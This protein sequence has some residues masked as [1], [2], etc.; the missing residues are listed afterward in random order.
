MRGKEF[1]TKITGSTSA[2][3][4]KI[5]DILEI[6]AGSLENNQQEYFHLSVAATMNTNEFVFYNRTMT[7]PFSRNIPLTNE[8]FK[9][10]KKL[11]LHDFVSD[12]TAPLIIVPYKNQT[13]DSFTV[14]IQTFENFGFNLKDINWSLNV[15]FSKWIYVFG[16]ELFAFRV[17]PFRLGSHLKNSKTP[18]TLFQTTLPF[19]P[20][21]DDE[22][23]VF[24][25]EYYP[26]LCQVFKL[27]LAIER[28][29]NNH[30]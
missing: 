19:K 12:K 23:L 7:I 13:N 21:N 27:P 5:I 25:L 8:T 9:Q 24:Y 4:S 11:L 10:I 6:I 14:E 30:R 3:D 28:M 18:I 2:F 16:S 15:E 22:F 1:R 26:S 20:G 17:C 29:R